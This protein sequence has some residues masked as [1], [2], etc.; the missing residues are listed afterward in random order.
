[1]QENSSSGK[2][3]ICEHCDSGDSAVSRCTNCSVF[4]CEF[5]ITAHK[6]IN[7]TKG[8]QMLSLEEVSAMGPKA[9]KTSSLCRKH[10]EET[11]K[12]FC[13]TCQLT[14]CRDCTIVDHRD[15]RYKFVSEVAD[16]ERKSLQDILQKTKNITYEVEEGLESVETMKTR[17]QIKAAE[18]N[19]ELDIFFAE[20]V[21]ALEHM[22]ANLK[23]EVG[24]QEQEK[25]TQLE[26]QRE[27][28]SSFLV[29]LKSGIDFTDQAI[30]DGDDS[31]L[32]SMKK[33]LVHRLAQLNS[34]QYQCQPCRSDYL[35]LHVHQRITNIG[36]MAVL[37]HFPV[38][39]NKCVVSMMGGEKGVTYNTVVNQ[40]V[41]F[42]LSV[43]G[44]AGPD[45]LVSD[46]CV[47][48]TEEGTL[49]V[50]SNDDGSCSFSFH[51]KLDF[52]G[53]V[54][55]SVRVEGQDVRGSPVRWDV[56]SKE[57]TKEPEVLCGVSKKM[58]SSD[59][60]ASVTGKG[61]HCWKLRLVSFTGSS[62]SLEIGVVETGL[63]RI[64][65]S[66]GP[67][68]K[69]TWCHDPSRLLEHQSTRSDGQAPSI[70]S[71]QNNDVFTVFLNLETKK[72][73]LY[74]DRS[75][76]TEVFTDV[77]SAK[78]KTLI[79]LFK[80]STQNDVEGLVFRNNCSY[81]TLDL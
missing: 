2:P 13:Q 50:F 54:V 61:A 42:V 77:K 29:Q 16:E 21:K 24:V 37:R 35:T 3:L 60:Q 56:E 46:D 67:N 80:P 9:L 74:N 6:R 69:W 8:H 26:N 23:H 53:P 57:Q 78:E 14:I 58:K 33:Q 70:T 43:E 18:V 19:K 20:Q 76:Q 75:K 4:M 36:D 44:E 71:V 5:C 12:L 27:M 59:G 11:L 22:Q 39:P 48:E 32:L 72:L 81:L 62:N 30:N 51:P 38:D 7:A 17:V 66:F 63:P 25:V 41:N 55:L 79:P 45:V 49:P 65:F 31:E 68:R 47:V 28:L 15:H 40:T 10:K 64:I 34:S 1:M 73:I 52:V